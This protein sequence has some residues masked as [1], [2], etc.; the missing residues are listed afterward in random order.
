MAKTYRPAKQFGKGF[1]VGVRSKVDY[2]YSKKQFGNLTNGG[3]NKWETV[4]LSKGYNFLNFTLLSS[5]LTWLV[6]YSCPID[7]FLV[8]LVAA[9]VSKIRR[10]IRTDFDNTSN[11]KV[12]GIDH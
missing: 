10:M 5:T 4:K 3:L 9:Y 2:Q 6:N 11:S 8:Q 1:K 12:L 7:L